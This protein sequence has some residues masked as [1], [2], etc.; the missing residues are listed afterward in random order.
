MIIALN[1]K[2]EFNQIEITS[3]GTINS[4]LVHPREVFSGLILSKAS[5]LIAVH[6]HPSGDVSPSN[7]DRK[8]SERLEAS[9][10]LLG[11]PMLDH[12]IIADDK[13]FSFKEEKKREKL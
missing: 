9:G 1:T 11:I 8:I 12:I 5:S 3:I 10:E 6:N 2:N 7:E 4:A 13:Y